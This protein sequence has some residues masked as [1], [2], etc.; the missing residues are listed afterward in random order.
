MHYRMFRLL[1]TKLLSWQKSLKAVYFCSLSVTK[2]IAYFAALAAISLHLDWGI[3]SF[4]SCYSSLLLRYAKHFARAIKYHRIFFEFP[5]TKEKH[6]A[7]RMP[8]TFALI[9]FV[10]H[11]QVFYRK[12]STVFSALKFALLRWTLLTD[13]H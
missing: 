10:S 5:T 4:L 9:Q 6:F 3:F 7:V 12:C 1:K 8:L 2:S 13:R 11:N